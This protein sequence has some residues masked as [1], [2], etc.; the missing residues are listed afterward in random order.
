[1]P[2]KYEVNNIINIVRTNVDF[3]ETSRSTLCRVGTRSVDG[4]I[5]GHSGRATVM[6]AVTVSGKKLPAFV[7][8][9]G[10]QMG[11][12]QENAGDQYIHTITSSMQYKPEDDWMVG[13]KYIQAVG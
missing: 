9:K 2:S 5:C 8:W 13:F 3:D 1:V 12:L 4:K 10:Y 6:L 7:I 11:R